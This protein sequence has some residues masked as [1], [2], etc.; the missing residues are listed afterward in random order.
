M[1]LS[2]QISS[3][4]LFNLQDKIAGPLRFTFNVAF[5]ASTET[6]AVPRSCGTPLQFVEHGIAIGRSLSK[7]L[8][9]GFEME[10]ASISAVNNPQ[11]MLVYIILSVPV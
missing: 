7:D 1:R 5:G 2:L 4:S 8:V 6:P 3:G 11:V 10:V 9:D